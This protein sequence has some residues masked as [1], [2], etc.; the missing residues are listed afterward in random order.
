MI[1]YN[2]WLKVLREIRMETYSE[3]VQIISEIIVIDFLTLFVDSYQTMTPYYLG[4][5][6]QR[7]YYLYILSFNS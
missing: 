3:F 4:F 5:L 6:A 2:E 7:N 1:I